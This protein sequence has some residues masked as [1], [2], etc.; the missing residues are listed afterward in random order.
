MG[1]LMGW[2]VGRFQSGNCTDFG[3]GVAASGPFSGQALGCESALP[4]AV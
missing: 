4:P 1:G 3:A 2:Y